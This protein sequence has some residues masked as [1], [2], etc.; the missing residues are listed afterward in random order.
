MMTLI[1]EA[2][3]FTPLFVRCHFFLDTLFSDVVDFS[4]V[5]VRYG[6]A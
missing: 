4:V 2:L 1:S 5:T 3:I 6:T